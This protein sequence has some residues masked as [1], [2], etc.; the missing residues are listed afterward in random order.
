VDDEGVGEV[1]A[2]GPF[3]ES[4]F[5]LLGDCPGSAL[6]HYCYSLFA[7]QFASVVS[8]EILV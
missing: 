8:P 6:V 4:E 7:R 2:A 1:L 5:S 3:I